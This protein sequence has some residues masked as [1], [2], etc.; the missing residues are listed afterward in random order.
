MRT[1]AGYLLAAF[2]AILQIFAYTTASG[3]WGF[4]PS[5]AAGALLL[6]FGL[7]LASRRSSR[8]HFWIHLSV[9]LFL[10][11][12]GI[13]VS[14]AILFGHHAAEYSDAARDYAE[15]ILPST[16]T[17]KEG[18]VATYDEALRHELMILSYFDIVRGPDRELKKN[19]IGRILETWT[20]NSVDLLR[21]AIKDSDYEIRSYASTALSAIEQRFNRAILERKA[22]HESDPGNPSGALNLASAYIAYA[23]SGLLD[24]DSSRFYAGLAARLLEETSEPGLFAVILR[25]RASRILGDAAAALAHY[26]RVLETD[27][28]HG[29]ALFETCR[30]AFDR[31][32]WSSLIAACHRFKETA[33][34]DHPALGAVEFW[35]GMKAGG[36]A[37]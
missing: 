17:V 24:A 2:G 28:V 13:V 25:A 20:P 19:L 8:L 16:A 7:D 11:L 10:P 31:R 18:E 33:P 1:A 9:N 15:Y 29:E 4:L 36:G 12:Y 5:V 22:E 23:R 26:A 27:P 6:A 3:P 35:T 32:D 37:A 34:D 30:L 14:V 21:L